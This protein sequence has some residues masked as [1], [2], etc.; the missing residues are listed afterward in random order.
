MKVI[1]T[2]TSSSFNAA[3]TFESA[4]KPSW[5]KK[6]TEL[7]SFHWLERLIVSLFRVG[8]SENTAALSAAGCQDV[9]EGFATKSLRE[10]SAAALQQKPPVWIQ[11]EQTDRQ[12]GGVL[13]RTNMN[14][15]VTVWMFLQVSFVRLST[16]E[17]V[18]RLVAGEHLVDGLC[19]AD[20]HSWVQEHRP[21][22]STVLQFEPW[23]FGLRR[24]LQQLHQASG[25][26]G[27]RFPPRVQ[28][29]AAHWTEKKHFLVKIQ[30]LGCR[31]EQQM[32]CVYYKTVK[33][34]LSQ[35]SGFI[36]RQFVSRTTE[37]M[38]F[39]ANS[40]R[41]VF[42]AAWNKQK[43]CFWKTIYTEICSE[44]RRRYKHILIIYSSGKCR[45]V[46]FYQI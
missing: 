6:T 7:C 25:G 36:W 46:V 4:V 22:R 43:T 39:G 15:S 37:M 9:L 19:G 8:L 24:R 12:S 38:L 10:V 45:C 30:I 33:Q 17:L 18:I 21:L 14:V 26:D 35:D 41:L 27:L 16:S 42:Q 44:I 29:D 34:P 31:S 1:K 5:C 13:E 3:L 23:T 28:S 32:G 11:Y 2:V 40:T 20:S